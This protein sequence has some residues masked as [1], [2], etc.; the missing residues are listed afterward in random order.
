MSDQSDFNFSLFYKFLDRLLS[1]F[2]QISFSLH[3]L[4]IKENID[5][6]NNSDILVVTNHGLGASIALIIKI[7]RIKNKKIYIINAQMFEPRVSNY[8]KKIIRN[9]FINLTINK[10]ERII[11][12]SHR[13]F[14][15]AVEM[16]PLKESKFISIPFCVDTDFWRTDEVNFSKKKGVLFVGQN[17]MRDIKKFLEIAKNLK[18]IEFTAVTT[19]IDEDSDIPTNVKII[20]GNWNLSILEDLELKHLYEKARL[21]ILPIKENTVACSGHSV[22]LQSMAVGT[23]VIM[24]KHG[25][26]WESV[27]ETKILLIDTIKEEWEDKISNLYKNEK[28]L[29]HLSQIGMNSTIENFN[30]QVFNNE[31][32]KLILS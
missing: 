14:E 10:S 31:M 29:M 5:A 27:D 26:F 9:Y 23:P 19:L 15:Y 1:K 16:K 24:N 6:I 20:R 8:F 11:F 30:Y 22:S 17:D 28:E 18:D 25:G 32:K 21:T 13:E 4:L 7:K 3:K 2:S 12:T